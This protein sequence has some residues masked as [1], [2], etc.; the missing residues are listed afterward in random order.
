MV[1]KG[2]VNLGPIPP[3]PPPPQAQTPAITHEKAEDYWKE[4]GR[5]VPIKYLEPRNLL[6]LDSGS[7]TPETY[8]IGGTFE[9]GPVRKIIQRLVNPGGGVEASWKDVA[10]ITGQS[11][12]W[13]RKE[14][15]ACL[16][17]GIASRHLRI[18][19]RRYQEWEVTEQVLKRLN[20]NGNTESNNKPP[21]GKP[22]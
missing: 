14:W 17:A 9:I 12:A 2:G 20:I 11:D 13:S 18:V 3:R 10:N 7:F 6:V 15:Q 5:Q 4:N 19:L 16:D 1:K 21:E 22:A 8:T